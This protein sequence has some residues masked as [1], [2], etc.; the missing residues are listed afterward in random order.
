[1][2]NT[3][4]TQ[5]PSSGQSSGTGASQPTAAVPSQGL[6]GQANVPASTLVQRSDSGLVTKQTRTTSG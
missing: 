4:Q 5:T 3:N 2:S 1:M 6:I